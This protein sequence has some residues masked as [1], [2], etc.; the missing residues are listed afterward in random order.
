MYQTRGNQL[1]L[2]QAGTGAWHWPGQ[3]A[4]AS[5]GL[6]SPC[7]SALLFIRPWQCQAWLFKSQSWQSLRLKIRGL[8]PTFPQDFTFFV[9]LPSAVPLVFPAFEVSAHLRGQGEGSAAQGRQRQIPFGWISMPELPCLPGRAV[10]PLLQVK[11]RWH[12]SDELAGGH[13]PCE[14]RKL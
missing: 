1:C 9:P 12:R 11:S 14:K 10:L 7:T 13:G 3:V 6:P 2:C 5:V 8:K 4:S